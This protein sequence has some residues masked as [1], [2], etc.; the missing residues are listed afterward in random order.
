MWQSGKVF[1]HK[2]KILFQ[3]VRQQVSCDGWWQLEWI[4][5]CSTEFSC[6]RIPSVHAWYSI[7]QSEDKIMV[8]Q[9]IEGQEWGGVMS[10][11]PRP[12]SHSS[13]RTSTKFEDIKSSDILFSQMDWQKF[14]LNCCI[15]FFPILCVFVLNNP[16]MIRGEWSDWEGDNETASTID[17]G[18]QGQGRARPGPGLLDG[19]ATTDW[20]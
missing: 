12:L 14:V 19:V 18:G 1:Y 10:P 2:E 4:S 9:P 8:W 11:Y 16:C 15:L 20:F 6:S 7:G 17:M 5:L 13:V 3:S